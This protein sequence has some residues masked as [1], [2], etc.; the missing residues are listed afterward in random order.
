MF[1]FHLLGERTVFS[2]QVCSVAF[3]KNQ[4]WCSD[5]SV[6]GL[7]SPTG[8]LV[9]PSPGPAYVDYCSSVMSLAS[10]L[11]FLF[12][13]LAVF[14]PSQFHVS[15]RS[16]CQVLQKI[17]VGFSL[18][19]HWIYRTFGGELKSLE[20]WVVQSLGLLKFLTSMW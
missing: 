4:V 20:Y 13:V 11:V 17:L 16:V 6:S 19:M 15:F 2:P 9:S 14:S 10:H 3:V 1:W 8:L 7:F 18:G 5:G 12:C